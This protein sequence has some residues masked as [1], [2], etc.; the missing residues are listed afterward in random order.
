M[1][2][3]VDRVDASAA[4]RFWRGLVGCLRRR[5]GRRLDCRF[6][7]DVASVITETVLSEAIID[8]RLRQPHEASASKGSFLASAVD[9]RS[10]HVVTS[11]EDPPTSR[12]IPSSV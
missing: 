1:P 5:Y 12:S 11:I 7:H 8:A 2:A 6:G 4:L 10:L 9:R 3:H